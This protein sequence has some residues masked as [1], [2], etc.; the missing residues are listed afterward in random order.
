VRRAGGDFAGGVEEAV[1]SFVQR[2]KPFQLPTFGKVG[3]KGIEKG[4]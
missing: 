1:C 4:A 2:V 3:M